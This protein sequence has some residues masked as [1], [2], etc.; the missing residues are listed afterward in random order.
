MVDYRYYI[1]TVNEYRRLTKNIKTKQATKLNG[2]SDHSIGRIPGARHDYSHL[3]KKGNPTLRISI[4][5]KNVI[6]VIKNGE[7]TEDNSKAEGY[8][9][10]GWKVVISKQKKTYGKVVTIKPQKQ[11]KKK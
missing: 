11:K 4:F 3:D 5:V 9:L 1:D 7:L 10:D 2:L 6:N 8:S